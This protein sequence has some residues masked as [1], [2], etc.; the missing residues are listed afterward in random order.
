[1]GLAILAEALA[2]IEHKLDYLLRHHNVPV[3]P[4]YFTGNACPVCNKLIEYQIDVKHQVVVR[5][6]D[7]TTGKIPSAI[8][9]SPVPQVGASNGNASPDAEAAGDRA[10]DSPRRKAR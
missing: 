8:P 6:C 9:L 2:R 5:R 1:M 3:L 7:C 4:M 10:E